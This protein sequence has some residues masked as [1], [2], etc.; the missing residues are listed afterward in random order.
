[1]GR[2]T[3]IKRFAEK[4]RSRE[5]SLREPDGTDGENEQR[6]GRLRKKPGDGQ[7]ENVES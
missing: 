2:R 4:K 5:R 1:V 3:A 6:R 7:T